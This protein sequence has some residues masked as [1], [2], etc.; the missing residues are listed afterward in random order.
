M[1]EDGSIIQNT[2]YSSV[3]YATHSGSGSI[4]LFKDLSTI[5]CG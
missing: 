4:T 3:F 5:R 1:A 2:H